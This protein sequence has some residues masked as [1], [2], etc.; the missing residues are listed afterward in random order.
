MFNFTIGALLSGVILLAVYIILFTRRR[1]IDYRDPS[2]LSRLIS[3]KDFEYLLIDARSGEKYAASHIPTA[4]NIPYEK[5]I[6]TLPVENMFL[7]I[8]VYGD[9]LKQASRAA[10]YLCVSGYFNVTA[11]G[12][13]ARWKGE[14]EKI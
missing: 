5:L 1:V 7:T 9:S 13:M 14:L 4:V 12:K 3:Q 6:G 2:R 10:E 8:I 11:F